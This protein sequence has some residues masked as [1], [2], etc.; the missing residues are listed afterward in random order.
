MTFAPS[1]KD[2]EAVAEKIQHY[3]V[4]TPTIRYSGAPIPGLEDSS[5]FI[6][7]E[8]LQHGGSFKVRGAFNTIMSLPDTANGVTAFSAGNH[9]IAVAYAAHKSGVSAKVV[10]PRSANPFRVERVK[11]WGADIV[12]GDT[13][14]DLTTIVEQLQ[15]DEQRVLIHP[16]EGER[17]IEGTATVGYELC[18]DVDLLDAI[19]VPVGGG[20]LI[21]GVASAV[22]Q[23]QPA[24]KVIG[25]EPTEA[26]GMAASIENGAPLDS[27]ALNSIADSLSAPMHLPLSYSFSEQFVDEFVQVTDDQMRDAMRFMFTEL[28]LAVEPA[29]AAAMAAL[30]GP[31][32]T[33][34]A[35]K[36]VGIIACGTNIDWQTYNGLLA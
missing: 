25:V 22:K 26:R 20:G 11:Y 34:M 6:K 23:L 3:V 24:A 31:L 18:M 21:A 4:R 12:F 27:V 36:R 10:M 29:C 33:S 15:Q 14:G 1:K 9:A 32:L 8:L 19:I 7:L 28:K 17:T 35:G 16:F 13:I 2:I 30:Q 5:L